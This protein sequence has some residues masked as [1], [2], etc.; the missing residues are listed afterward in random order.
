MAADELKIFLV[1]DDADYIL[2]TRELLGGC[3]AAMKF[4]SAN[5]LAA[6][7]PEIAGWRPDLVLL[8]LMLPDSKGLE[9]LRAVCARFPSLPVIVMTSISDKL[10]GDEAVAEGAQ[11][12][13]VKGRSDSDALFRTIKYSIE[14]KS[15]LSEK[16][17]LISKL[18]E[19]LARVKQL[20]G[21]LPICFGCKKIKDEDGKWVKLETYLSGHSEAEFTH[22]LCGDCLKKYKKRGRLTD[23]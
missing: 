5:T 7:V 8:D 1:E 6:A 14:R 16:E 15:L 2:L 12:Y 10:L 21:L 13:L 19:A 9:T 11:D 18:R 23:R 17:K 3:A 22:G 20:S 4:R